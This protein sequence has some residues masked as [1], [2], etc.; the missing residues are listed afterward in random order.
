MLLRA[1]SLSP[2]K[3]RTHKMEMEVELEI[4][5]KQ[6]SATD[7]SNLVLLCLLPPQLIIL[8]RFTRANNRLLPGVKHNTADNKPEWKNR[9][10]SLRQVSG[11]AQ[12][13]TPILSRSRFNLILSLLG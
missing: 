8:V 3:N 13:N 4:E 2:E 7:H 9:P 12:L 10:Q 5:G 1:E 11:A 6:R